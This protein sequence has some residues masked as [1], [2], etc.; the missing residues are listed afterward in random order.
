MIHLKNVETETRRGEVNGAVDGR[1]KTDS[2]HPSF[3]T[4]TFHC[5]IS[6]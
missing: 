5:C 1:V 4:V 2:S 3:R 6:S